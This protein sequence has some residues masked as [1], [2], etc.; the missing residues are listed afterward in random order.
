MW[1]VFRYEWRT[2]RRSFVIWAAI[3]VL[4]QMMF[5]G[6]GDMYMNNEQLLQA[7]D[8]FPQAL[9]E[10]FGFH[11][12]MLGSFEGWM[13]GEPLV[14]FTMLLGAFAAIW[15]ASTVSRE[16][17]GGTVD[18]MFTLPITRG[19]LFI[20]KVAAHLSGLLLITAFCYGVTL[21]FGQWFSTI[22][23]AA[24]LLVYMAAGALAALAFAG[25]GYLI[26]VFVASERAG[27]AISIGIVIISFLLNML[28]GMNESLSWLSGF[29]LFT[30]FSGE[31][32]FTSG[33]LP[34]DGVFITILVYIVGVLGGWLMLSRRDL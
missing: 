25:I 34:W 12:E 13:G 23:D 33:S 6:V 18:F 11:A 7:L 1:Q 30:I 21:L 31:E 20:G 9:L 22:E 29:S 5:A 17:D 24:I 3:I 28:A 26:T 8:Q 16:R 14:F 10:G 27:L 2:N 32:M 19:G 15:A 4:F